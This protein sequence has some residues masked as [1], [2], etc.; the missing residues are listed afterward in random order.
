MNQQQL[1]A[2]ER[3]KKA[4]D[5]LGKVGLTLY[6]HE[7]TCQICKTFDLPEDELDTT[8]EYMSELYS[9]GKVVALDDI[10]IDNYNA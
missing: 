5:N 10:T 4:H 2:I 6:L 7:S 1:K 8:E 3:F 9:E